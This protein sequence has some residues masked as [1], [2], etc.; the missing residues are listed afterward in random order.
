VQYRRRAVVFSQG[1][2]GHDVRYIQTG[3]IKLP[4]LSRLGKEAVV[5]MLGPGDFFGEGVLMGQ[6]VRRGTA[7]AVVASRVLIIEKAA[8]VRLLHDEA[9]F[10]ARFMAYM[11]SRNMRMESD[12]VDRVV[13]SIRGRNRE[14][15]P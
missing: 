5:A 10:S 2:P 8:I 11:L 4:V 9:T 7:T 15:L 1:D 3:A 13:L 14:A 12:L 6:S